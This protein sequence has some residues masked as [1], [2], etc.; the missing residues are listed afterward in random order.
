MKKITIIFIA[1][2]A[3]AMNANAQQTTQDS[4]INP[5]GT[6]TIH[7]KT[8]AVCDMCK[9][10]M[11]LAMSYEKGVKSSEL[12]VDTKILTVTYLPKKTDAN[13]VRIA[14]NKTGYD[15]DQLPADPKAYNNLHSCCKKDAGHE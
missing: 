5:D 2:V 3:I 11:E 12:N 8:S 13:K 9:E 14:V 1:L 6:V 15:A 4:I 7:I 10:T